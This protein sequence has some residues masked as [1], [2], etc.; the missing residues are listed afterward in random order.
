MKMKILLALAWWCRTHLYQWKDRRE[1]STRGEV[2]EPEK[3]DEQEKEQT[4][5]RERWESDPGLQSASTSSDVTL[6]PPVPYYGDVSR[7]KSPAK[8]VDTLY[9]DSLIPILSV[10]SYGLSYGLMTEGTRFRQLP[11]GHC[12]VY[13]H[14]SLSTVSSLFTIHCRSGDA[15]FLEKRENSMVDSSLSSET[16]NGGIHG[17]TDRH[18][19]KTQRAKVQE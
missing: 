16:S 19:G 5:A 17:P 3:P 4:L 15:E 13:Y 14:Y 12:H 18:K 1:Y 11:T 2:H 6:L 10:T 8:P 9:V 7:V